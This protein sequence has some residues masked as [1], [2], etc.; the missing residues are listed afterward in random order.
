MMI[1]SCVLHEHESLIYIHLY[2][3]VEFEVAILSNLWWL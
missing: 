1:E 2:F 3:I